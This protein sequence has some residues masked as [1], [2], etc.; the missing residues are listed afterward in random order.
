MDP[1][2]FDTIARQLGEARSRRGVLRALGAGLAA[3]LAATRASGARAQGVGEFPCLDLT[4]C[5][6]YEC[7]VVLNDCSFRTIGSIPGGPYE[8]VF[9]W[10]IPP[11][12]PKNKT[13]R[14]LEALCN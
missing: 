8:Q 1:T 6:V 5:M 4:D 13:M 11:C 3:A 12:Q 9:T 10:A 2:R 7:D 14:E